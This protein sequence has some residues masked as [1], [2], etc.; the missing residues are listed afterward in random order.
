MS[1]IDDLAD[2]LAGRPIFQRDVRLMSGGNWKK[3]LVGVMVMPT[4]G[5]NAVVIHLGPAHIALEWRV[6]EK[7]MVVDEAAFLKDRGAGDLRRPVPY[8]VG[9]KFTASDSANP[10][11][12]TADDIDV[13]DWKA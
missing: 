3:W 5:R 13:G 10:K 7:P 12:L 11:G 2:A 6:R 9:P 1:K 8:V 4:P